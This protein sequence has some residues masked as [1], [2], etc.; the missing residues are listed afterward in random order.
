MDINKIKKQVIIDDGHILLQKPIELLMY[1]RTVKIQPIN[2]FYDWRDF[3]YCL[4]VF[5]Q[6]YYVI[7]SN[8]KLPEKLSE[9]KEFKENV[10]TAITNK[11]AFKML[12][13]ICK[14]SGFKLRWMKKKF[15]LDDWVEVFLYVFFFNIQATKKSL[16]DALKATG[17]AQLV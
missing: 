10:R 2:W 17:K 5:L 9:L 8:S 6:Y 4:G 7:C 12:M 15:T 1:G 16:Y 14:Y 3:S 13:R 11:K